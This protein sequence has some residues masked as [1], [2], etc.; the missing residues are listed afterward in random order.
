MSSAGAWRVTVPARSSWVR[1]AIWTARQTPRR[2]RRTAERCSAHARRGVQRP[3]R[4]ACEPD[5]TE[6]TVVAGATAT[7]TVRPTPADRRRSARCSTV[8]RRVRL[9]RHVQRRC[10]R[11]AHLG[12]RRHEKRSTRLRD[13]GRVWFHSRHALA[14]VFRRRCVSENPRSGDYATI[15]W[16]SDNG[17]YL[18][19]QHLVGP[20]CRQLPGALRRSQKLP[21]SLVPTPCPLP[22]RSTRT[23]RAIR[24]SSANFGVRLR[25]RRDHHTPCAA[26]PGCQ[27][28]L[29]ARPIAPAAHVTRRGDTA[30][31]MLCVVPTSEHP[32][33]IFRILQQDARKGARMFDLPISRLDNG[34][35]RRIDH[36][37]LAMPL[38]GHVR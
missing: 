17:L 22:R 20:V 21:H 29:S 3:P 27:S 7:S 38:P 11:R 30:L 32:P 28:P 12:R 31:R 16:G 33:C 1:T 26:R 18:L 14:I 25:H 23:S 8:R 2:R 35:V 4:S 37:R 5:G 13:N 34:S 36:A 19:A 24:A 9:R 10:R 6:P 15:H